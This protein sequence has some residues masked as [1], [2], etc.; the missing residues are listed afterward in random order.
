MNKFLYLIIQL[1]IH[2]WLLIKYPIIIICKFS[3]MII[4]YYS[5]ILQEKR[6]LLREAFKNSNLFYWNKFSNIPPYCASI[7]PNT[8]ETTV[9]SFIRMLIE[10]PEVSLNGSPTVSPTTAAL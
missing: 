7:G 4:P 1:I 3:K 8:S 6:L 9:I 10:G 2:L 5:V